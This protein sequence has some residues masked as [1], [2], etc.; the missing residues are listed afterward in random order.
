[1]Q[2][3]SYRT[4]LEEFEQKANLELYRYWS[5][6]KNRFEIVSL[7]ADYSDLFCIESVREIESALE[8]ETFDSRRKSLDKIRRLLL[9]QYLECRAAPLTEEISR[10]ETT[11]T[12]EG[13]AIQVSQVQALLRN[14]PDAFKRRQLN[15]RYVKTLGESAELR[16]RKIE[17]LRSASADLGFKNYLESEEE[18]GGIRFE[19]L[20]EAMDDVLSRS[21][22]QYFEQ[23]RVSLETSLGIPYEET[24]SWDVAHWENR[25]DQLRVFSE[26]NLT[27]VVKATIS[28]LDAIPEGSGTISVDLDRRK[29]KH[30]GPFCI[31]VRI[32]QEIK[33][34]MIPGD[35]FQYHAAL[36]HETGHA[37]H[38]A[39][40]SPSLP[41]E[42][43]IFGD[44]ALSEA[45]AFLFE[46]FLQ[47][48]EWLHRML[49]FTRA[50]GF[51]HFQGL[52]RMFQIRRC[53]GKLR[54]AIKLHEQRS[55]D[56][57]PQIYSETMKMYTGLHHSPE[58]WCVD[59]EN[60][61]T[62]ADYLRGWA[63]EAMLREYLRTKYGNAWSM[64]RSASGFLKEVW[65]TGML[66]RADELCHAIGLGDLEPQILA[67]RLWEG[68][69]S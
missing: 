62:S 44:R 9:D 63:L 50:A 64:N 69:Q 55:F 49:G 61:F 15:D 25:N 39:W 31:P 18:I 56:D 67:D 40:T 43:R 16:W 24:G 1:M 37:L 51:L 68:L 27:A 57:M 6:L 33:I 52:Y 5:G 35:G 48:R 66:Y 8:K 2:I 12:S 26:K 29:G 19:K 4:R 42:H 30:P 11:V 32:P 45:Y 58:Y 10:L 65:E 23:W 46:N 54:I 28:D 13:M 34:G 20:L 7:Y 14:E 59:I 21:E 36:L 22:D 17:Q 3:E 60:D 38:F 47:E 41:M 53:A